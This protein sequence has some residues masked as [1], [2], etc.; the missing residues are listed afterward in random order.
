[1]GAS[2]KK[3]WSFYENLQA[4]EL[5]TNDCFMPMSRKLAAPPI[6]CTDNHHMAT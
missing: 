4:R 2:Y 6:A 3:L 1:M 5:P